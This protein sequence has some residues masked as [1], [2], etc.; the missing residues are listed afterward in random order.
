M[1]NSATTGQIQPPEMPRNEIAVAPS[2]RGLEI[3]LAVMGL[4][5]VGLGIAF[6]T[7]SNPFTMWMGIAAAALLASMWVMIGY[8]FNLGDD[9]EM[10]KALA[11]A[12]TAL[13]VQLSLGLA[14]ALSAKTLA[15]AKMLTVSSALTSVMNFVKL[16]I[17]GGSPTPPPTQNT[18]QGGGHSG[19]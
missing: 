5:A 6:A 7:T 8:L 17:G 9:D 1:P 11:T 13:A 4:A 3:A 16:F 2:H 12:Y 15:I 19:R 10:A 18:G 14:L